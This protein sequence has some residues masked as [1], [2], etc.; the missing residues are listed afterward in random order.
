MS[1]TPLYLLAF[2]IVALAA[3][4][5][6]LFL[7]RLPISWPMAAMAVGALL[8]GF[9]FPKTQV[10]EFHKGAEALTE[11]ALVLAVMGG[12]LRIDRRFSLWGWAST[13]RLLG[14]LMPISIGLVALAGDALLGLP[15]G[16]AILLGAMLSPTDPVLAANVEVGP[17]G[18][19][20]EGEVKF[21]LTSEAGL[22]DGLAFPFV[23]LGLTLLHR[24]E[25]R[26]DWLTHWF[27]IDVLWRVFAAL[28][29][30]AALGSLFAKGD[31]ILAERL[32]LSA[33]RSEGLVVVALSF[34]AYGL[35]QI[36]GVY[37]FL[38]V[39]ACAVA[40]RNTSPNV[41]IHRRLSDF[42]EQIERFATSAVLLFFGGMVVQRSLF[43]VAWRDMALAAVALFVA[44]PVGVAVSFLGSSLDFRERVVFAYFGIRGL[45]TLY[46]AA[47][48]RNQGDPYQSEIWPA[49]FLIVLVS[50]VLY[51]TTSDFVMGWLA[52]KRPVKR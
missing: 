52:N 47:Y 19:G 37:G 8:F 7:K 46:Y 4:W 26:P 12:G 20:E 5:V 45:A 43:D 15:P 29:L 51:G 16:A 10:M 27:L 36:V 9:V 14:L 21:G 44:R 28:G 23:L 33:A 49:A 1:E 38:S 18:S 22:N 41:D 2:A 42:A 11:I 35:A 34:L 40:I 3:A 48:A 6:P 25:S 50:I 31:A 24:Q 13:L 17:P 39:F 32:R 30:G